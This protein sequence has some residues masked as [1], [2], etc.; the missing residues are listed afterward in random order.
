MKLYD[1]RDKFYKS[2]FG[3]V[4][5]GESLKL[6]LLVH[7]DARV[8]STYLRVHRDREYGITEHPLTPAEN[9][10]DYRAFEC[11]IAFDTGLYF[12]SFRYLSDYGEF[13]ITADKNKK[14]VISPDGD[15]WQLTCYDKDF[16]TPEWLKGGIIYQIFPDRFYASGKRK[17]LVPKDRYIVKD[18]TNTPEFR[19]KNGICSLGNDYYGGDLA[20][21]NE[22]L[23]Y[24]SSL[25]VTCIYLNPIF[26]AHSNHRYN[27]ADYTK[28]DPLLGSERDL[29]ALC[30]KAKKYGVNIILDGV[31]SHTG[32]DS[33][34]F[35]EYRRYTEV[36]AAES[37]DSPYRSWYKFDNSRLGYSAWWGVPSLPEINE[38]DPSFTEF[39][40][41]EDGI[42]KRWVKCGIKGWRLDV[43]DE[44]PDKFLD[45]L[46]IALKSS[47][48]DAFLLGEVWEDASNK[49][50][51]NERRRYLHGRQLDSVMNY[52][53]ADAVI[54]F[55]RGGDGYEFTEKIMTILENYPKASVDLLMNHLGT[56]DTAR[57]LTNLGHEGE[58]PKTRAEQAV[59]KLSNEEYKTG[60]QRLRIAAVLQYTL[61][62]VPSLYY[63]DEA[64]MEGFGDP[65]CRGFYPWGRENTELLE[66]YKWLGTF[67]KENSVFKSGEFIPVVSGLG[68]VA[69]IRESENEKLLIAVNRWCDADTI[70][71]PD[72]FKD[73]TVLYGN[74][75]ENGELR[76]NAVDFSIIKA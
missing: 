28:I 56:H 27:T 64:G 58:H 30:K 22:K 21:I 49:I 50:S 54:K 16:K 25:G 75:P 40:T 9:F 11:E 24:L 19:Q 69:F 42:I 8:S 12:Y 18:K 46:R 44:L 26:E 33:L 45:K 57:I 32:N 68:T 43:A 59:S 34:Y 66:F 51:Y 1:S 17:S 35:N 14:G 31:F 13:F 47:D 41:G 5:S 6:R 55:V 2:K 38:D 74:T 39:I 52:P 63:G 36:G 65:F 71:L 37:V 73:G 62:G 23:P 3:A 67:R 10:G 7:N 60:V 70:T 20:G 53:F 4:A 76:V 29:K 48:P 61:P 15:W 72:D